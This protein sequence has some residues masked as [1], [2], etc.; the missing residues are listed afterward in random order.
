MLAKRD[1]AKPTEPSGFTPQ[2]EASEKAI[3]KFAHM[4]FEKKA[5][6]VLDR[7]A[8]W[9]AARTGKDKATVREAQ[10]ASDDLLLMATALQ[11]DPRELQYYGDTFIPALQAATDTQTAGEGLEFVPRLLSN[12]LIERINL[13]LNVLNLF[14]MVPMPS[15][16]FDIPGR[17]VNRVRQGKAVEQTADTGQTKFAVS[18]PGTR[19]V[20]LTAAKFA[21]EMLTSKELEEDALIAILPFMREELVDYLA[22]DLEDTAINGQI[23]GTQDTDSAGATDPRRNWDGLRARTIAGGKTDGGNAALTVAMLRTNRKNMGKYGVKPNDLAHILSINNYIQLLSD[24][25]VITMD[26]YGNMATILDGELGK[27]DGSPIIVSEYQRLNL[28]AT[29]VFDNV[30]TNRS[31]ALT[32]NRRGFIRRERRGISLQLLK[33]V[34]AESDQDAIIGTLRQAFEARFPT[35]TEKVVASTYNL[36]I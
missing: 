12:D 27:V 6:M 34:Y 13:D 19:K 26:K 17:G 21:G 9:V 31:L 7:P 23:L 29:G 20:T 2:D 11:K 33:E 35:A 16:P 28:N 3:A 30:T 36:A 10:M 5:T 24:T 4:A 1:A 8:E 15:N 22:A 14:N 18:T 32:V 25:N